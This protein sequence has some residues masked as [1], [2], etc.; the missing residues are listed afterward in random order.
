MELKPEQLDFA[1]ILKS[2]ERLLACVYKRK[3]QVVAVFN[4]F[5]LLFNISEEGG[6]GG[7]DGP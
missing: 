6:I 7:A 4:Y 3:V 2:S 1:V 5:Y